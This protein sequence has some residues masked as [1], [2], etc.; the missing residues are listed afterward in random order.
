MREARSLINKV[1]MQ[2]KRP[3]AFEATFHDLQGAI[4]STIFFNLMVFQKFYGFCQ[5][6]VLGTKGI[7]YLRSNIPR[8]H[9]T[10]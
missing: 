9:Y 10:N 8:H 5:S 1:E 7:I 3:I 2:H 6:K 4:L